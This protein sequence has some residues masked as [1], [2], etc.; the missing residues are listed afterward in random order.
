MKKLVFCI[1]FVLMFIIFFINEKL[2][3]SQT[4]D[5]DTPEKDLFLQLNYLSGELRNSAADDMQ[6]IYPEGFIFTN[7][8]YG[9]SWAEIARYKNIPDSIKRRALSEAEWAFNEIKS[10]R[11]RNLFERNKSLCPKYGIF[12][13]GWKNYL[14]ASIL[15]VK[16]K[17]SEKEKNDF[18]LNCDSLVQC[19]SDLPVPYPES[20]RYSIWPADAFPA[21]A[22]LSI[23]DQI[24]TPKYGEFILQWLRETEK[25]LDPKTGLIPHS[26]NYSNYK[27]R[28]A[29][30]GS[31]T[32]LII[33]LM[34]EIDRKKAKEYYHVFKENFYSTFLGFP[35][36]REYPKGI[37]GF[38][39]IDSGP[40]I[41]G[42]GS[43]ATIVS[44]GTARAVGDTEI[45]DGLSKLIEIIGLPI[46]YHDKKMYGFG[47][48]PIG[49]LFICWSKSTLPTNGINQEFS[50][51]SLKIT[52]IILLL[53][54]SV[55]IFRI[56]LRMFS[57][58]NKSFNRSVFILASI[59]FLSFILLLIIPENNFQNHLLHN[60]IH[61]IPLK[62]IA[63]IS[64]LYGFI[65]WIIIF[66]NRKK[67]QTKKYLL[68][69]PFVLLLPF[70]Y[71]IVLLIQYLFK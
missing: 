53:I 39:D 47:L 66:I 28:E 24:F 15:R 11:G 25:Y 62:I 23:H 55:L 3:D 43:A 5:I 71:G 70:I 10:E 37:N 35:V 14:K 16:P 51:S 46:Q 27:F 19:F 21:I 64:G 2:N 34:A 56:R 60:I 13:F 4:F 22:S 40:V 58:N 18:K 59:S 7:V 41:F 63:E 52:S 17:I 33:R 49:D 69:L 8:L 1:S 36:I 45:S 48:H 44:I 38:G 26:V 30:R 42:V 12:Y 65:N 32:S 6:N 67:E 29:A 31:S 61:I 54:L 9:L 20:Y 50:F 57:D 68:Y